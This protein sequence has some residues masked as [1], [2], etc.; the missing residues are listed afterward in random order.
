MLPQ[1]GGARHD[2]SLYI[3]ICSSRLAS[4]ACDRAA[5]GCRTQCFVGMACVKLRCHATCDLGCAMY[6]YRIV[7]WAH[8]QHAMRN[9]QTWSI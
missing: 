8:R 6:S 7:P 2:D 9:A 3:I 5:T 1:L 4:Y